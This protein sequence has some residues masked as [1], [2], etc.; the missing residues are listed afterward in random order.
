MKRRYAEKNSIWGLYKGRRDERV[1]KNLY[2][3][4]LLLCA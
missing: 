3:S 1:R 4:P 2:I